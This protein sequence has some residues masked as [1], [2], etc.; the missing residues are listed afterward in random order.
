MSSDTLSRPLA[1]LRMVAEAYPRMGRMVN[2]LRADRDKRLPDWPDWCFL[3]LAGWYA[4]AS[5]QHGVD[6]LSPSQAAE[7]APL[8]ALGT[9]RY[10]QGVYRPNSDALAALA[11]SEFGGNLPSDLFLRLPEWCVYVETPGLAFGEQPTLGFWAHLESDANDSHV[12][13]RLL[14]HWDAGLLPIVIYLGAWPLDEAIARSFATSAANAALI[15][16]PMLTP[17]DMPARMAAAV[18]PYLSLLLYLCSDEPD[19]DFSRVPNHW[20][21]RPRPEKTKYGWQL[22]PAAAPRIYAVG[23]EI[24]RQLREA[25][26]APPGDPTGRHI[27][28]HVRRGHWHGYWT[29]PRTG[30]QKFVYRWLHP[31]VAGGKSA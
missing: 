30:P 7:L 28:A 16:L 19:I 8:A 15:G 29:G 17:T 9:W 10:T 27:R 14:L 4:V 3:P 18:Q 21:G 1:T 25:D 22:F 31:Y 26:S 23:Q 11:A 13:L 5:D 20:P 12:E 2:G 24:G 6:W